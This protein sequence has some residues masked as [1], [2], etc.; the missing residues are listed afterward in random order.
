MDANK[1]ASFCTTASELLVQVTAYAAQEPA[2]RSAEDDAQVRQ[3]RVAGGAINDALS[4]VA[5]LT[6]PIA[7]PVMPRP[8]PAPE[9][10]TA[11]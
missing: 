5:R 4:Q 6:P 10:A 8:A 2:K 1:V 11:T 3:L 9:P 7:P